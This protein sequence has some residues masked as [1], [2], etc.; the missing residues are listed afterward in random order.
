MLQSMRRP[1]G[2]LSVKT[3]MGF[4][5]VEGLGFI[6]ALHRSSQIRELGN[7]N[8]FEAPFICECPAIVSS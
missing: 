7:A 5:S 3:P 2:V 6:V 4:G 8:H 1:I